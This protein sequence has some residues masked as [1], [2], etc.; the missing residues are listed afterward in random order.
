[1]QTLHSLSTSSAL[2]I[3]ILSSPHSG[4]HYFLFVLAFSL[5]NGGSLL[6]NEN[7]VRSIYIFTYNSVSNVLVFV[8]LQEI[9]TSA[10]YETARL[11]STVSQAVAI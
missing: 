3:Y 8:P 9:Q 7:S 1:M 6:Q 2:S 10:S 4:P 11:R 5:L